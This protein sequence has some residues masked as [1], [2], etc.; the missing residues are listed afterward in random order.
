M[1][2]EIAVRCSF[3]LRLLSFASLVSAS[4]L[5]AT[6]AF[7]QAP[8]RPLPRL[9]VSQTAH[10]FGVVAEGESLYHAFVLQN[11]GEA[12]LHLGRLNASCGLEASIAGPKE[13]APG[14]EALLGVSFDTGGFFGK[15]DRTI[16][17]YTDD[18]RVPSQSFLLSADI[19]RAVKVNPPR[20]YFGRFKRGLES[21]LVFSVDF[22]EASPASRPLAVSSTS[23]FVKVEA[24]PA[25]SKS[26]RRF[27]YR[28]SLDD[29]LPIGVFRSKLRLRTTDPRTP[30]LSLPIF[31]RVVGDLELNPKTL[32]FGLLEAPLKEDHHRDFELYCGAAKGVKVLSARV[33]HPDM[34]L[35]YRATEAGRRYTF[36][37]TLPRGMRRG[38][39]R[40]RVK[41]V[42]NH[43]DEAQRELGLP[44]YAIL[45]GRAAE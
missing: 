38:L 45:E 20:L 36:R 6:W 17:L 12:P 37:L 18:P 15:K 22:S 13:L 39:L 34:K 3:S 31:A 2:S 32:S 25:K 44:V 7:A 43:G 24:M 33:D 14:A 23:K 19:R 28:V 9:K 1:P 26:V 21:S 35:T 8:Q 30:L 41:I 29:S 5:L 27:L 16:R 10:D 40:S 42:T 11:I 4:V